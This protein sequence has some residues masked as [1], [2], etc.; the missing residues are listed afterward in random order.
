LAGLNDFRQF[1]LAAWTVIISRY[2]FMFQIPYIP[3]MLFH[4][5]DLACFERMFAGGGDSKMNVS[6][7]DLEG[8]K[9]TF[10]RKGKN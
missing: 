3:E 8:Y 7:D 6:K 1:V 9:Y 4:T 2:I 10:S 5:E